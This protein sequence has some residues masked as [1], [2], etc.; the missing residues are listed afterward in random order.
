MTTSPH[1]SPIPSTN[2]N[3]NI[4]GEFDDITG[5]LRGMLDRLQ[6]RVVTLTT[7]MQISADISTR[8]ANILQIDRLLPEIAEEVKQG[9][10]LHHVNIYL[11]DSAGENLV[12][13]AATGEAGNLLLD[14]GYSVPLADVR[15]PSSFAAQQR[16]ALIINDI[17]ADDRFDY[18]D[19]AP[20]ARSKMAVPMIYQGKV[21][22]VL[23]VQ[24]N[25]L[26]RFDDHDVLVKTSLAEQVAVAIQNAIT[27]SERAQAEQRETLA[28]EIGQQLNTLQDIQTL[29]QFAVDRL[30]SAFK[31]YHV[32]IYRLDPLTQR[33]VVAAGLG[34]AGRVMT[35]G[36]HSIA[37][38][39]QQSLVATALR[40]LSPSVV[41]DVANEETYLPNPLIPQTRSE[42]AVPL[43]VGD[44]RYGVLDVQSDQAQR[45]EENE[46]RL[47][48]LVASQLSATLANL[49]RQAALEE[50]L[51]SVALA[52]RAAQLVASDRNVVD[53]LNAI[54][55]LVS[56]P[57][58]NDN[59]AYT[60][61]E[62]QTNMWQ[63]QAGYGMTPEFIAT[64]R[65]AY[66][67][68][69][70]GVD[71]LEN[72]HVVA[73]NNA[74]EYERFPKEYIESIGIKSVIV[75]PIV[76]T[77]EKIGTIYFN[78]NTAFHTFTAREIS[79]LENVA[80][81]VGVGVESRQAQ[82]KLARRAEDLLTASQ[83]SAQVTRTLDLQ[84]LL[85]FTVE[86]VKTGYDLYHAHIYLLDEA[87]GRMVLQA[88]AGEAGQVMLKYKHGIS[89][90]RRVSV[91]IQAYRQKSAVIVAD[92]RQFAN[93][94]PNP[95][96][97]KTRAEIAVPLVYGEDVI[98][99][100]DMQSDKV[101]RFSE[102]DALVF[103]LLAAQLAI[104][105]VNARNFA[106][107]QAART[108][109]EHRAQELQIVSQISSVVS[110]LLDIDELLGTVVEV[111]KDAFQLYHT[112]IYLFDPAQERLL[113]ASGAGEAGEVMKR[114][115]HQIS[116]WHPHSIVARA[117]R[118]EIGV[119]VEDVNI[120]DAFMP[121]PLLPFT[122]SEMAVPMVAANRLIGV[123]DLQSDQ[124]GR[125]TPSDL[126]IFTT[127]GA[128][129]AVAVENARAYGE[130]L[131]VADKLREVDRLKSEFLASMSH[132]L[133]T[134]LNS[135][136]GYSEVMLDGG[137]GELPTEASEDID[138][139]HKS[140]RHL[141]AIINDILDLAKIEAQQMQ[142]QAK[143]TDLVALLRDVLKTNA[144]LIGDKPV[145]VRLE[146][147]VDELVM[148]LDDLRIRQIALN[149]FSN[150]VKFTERGSITI[151]LTR[152]DTDVIVSFTDTGIGISEEGQT[153]VFDRFRQVD[154][155]STRKAGG[156]GLGLA[157]TRSLVQL[158]GGEIYVKSALG[159][160]STF[161]FNLPINQLVPTVI[162]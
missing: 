123:L 151:Q 33:L 37:L 39:A 111:T 23:G 101:G 145:E 66:E 80:R 161:W 105:V 129:I 140:G 4:L 88:G 115:R 91:V 20:D 87:Q 81:Q 125:F 1:H 48:E 85:N 73:V 160:G 126:T 57:L 43:Y 107:E 112:H 89:L 72:N 138:I 52:N 96:L 8:V 95:M 143:P 65:T 135:I 142:L 55:E 97:P 155:S 120:S 35:Q 36:G 16:A 15:S 11:I 38:A 28:Y 17:T 119:R 61:Y 14:K 32:H 158:H 76:G 108:V 116:L 3:L 159:Q 94:L 24:A 102:E 146:T 51:R 75:L 100:L 86:Q 13:S 12:L 2:P 50:E 42:V 141:L 71:A 114:N 133:R 162:G 93:F 109:N 106:A 149:L 6:S 26:N 117:A 128:Q 62:A 78:F 121:N 147:N 58:G 118:D 60:A 132:E 27:L 136:I 19:L 34:E 82:V 77:H 56:L 49:Q 79:L 70:H 9:F 18:G 99:V 53:L 46:V 5:Q 69:P 127:L 153:I 68:I 83:I 139:I 130:S 7:D 90:D 98:G 154:G 47:L 103:G 31:Y 152:G 137:D 148:P 134:P 144:V 104:A 54:C 22:G 59:A 64:I 29:M 113:L 41:Q 131:Q 122:H 10:K 150:A 45:F 156:T 124:V 74:Y 92:V 84:A 40:S 110:N 21:V 30:A 44:E 25:T 157:V 63:G 67:N